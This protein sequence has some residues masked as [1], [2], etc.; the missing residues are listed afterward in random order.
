MFTCTQV[1]VRSLLWL[2]LGLG[3]LTLRR[4]QATPAFTHA[5][6]VKVTRRTVWTVAAVT[7]ML[8]RSNSALRLLFQ[9]VHR[10]FPRGAASP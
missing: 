8:V 10:G 7:S 3:L 5:R 4:I 1:L 2:P 9:A 6:Q